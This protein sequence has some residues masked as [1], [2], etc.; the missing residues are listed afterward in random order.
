MKL[1][2]NVKDQ[3]TAFDAKYLEN[4]LR[5]SFKGIR[6]LTLK[7]DHY[8]CDNSVIVAAYIISIVFS[9]NESPLELALYKLD[10]AVFLTDKSSYEIR[11]DTIEAL[12]TCMLNFFRYNRIRLS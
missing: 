4:K 9:K 1:N 7:Q 11:A 10:N 2:F 5:S 8:R 6:S 3:I 12:T